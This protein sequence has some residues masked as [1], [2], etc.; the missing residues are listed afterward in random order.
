AAVPAVRVLHPHQFEILL[1]VR[2]LLLQRQVAEADLDPLDG[3]AVAE[4]GL[5]HVPQIL[6]AGYGAGPQRP[7][8]DG[9]E[10]VGL[11]PRLDPGRYQ[12]AHAETLE[13][14]SEYRHDGL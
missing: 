13:K 5:L 3:A 12:I 7:A 2:P 10:Q 9:P 4:P 8:F 6:V 1:P 11:P 14:A